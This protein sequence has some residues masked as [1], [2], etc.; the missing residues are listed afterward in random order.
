MRNALAHGYDAVNLVT[1]WNT[2][3]NDL[4]LMLQ[5]VTTILN[6]QDERG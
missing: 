6:A 1:V 5:C 2:V 3:K 4:P